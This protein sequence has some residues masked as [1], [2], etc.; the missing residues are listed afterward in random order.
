[1]LSPDDWCALHQLYAQAAAAMDYGNAADY[2]ALYTEDGAFS[3][4]AAGKE[5]FRHEGREALTTFA[6]GVIDRN[7]GLA[8]HWQCNIVLTPVEGGAR[9]T[10]HTMLVGTIRDNWTCNVL[11]IGQYDDRFV[12]TLE[13]W[14]ISRRIVRGPR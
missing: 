14:R 2:A 11:L 7:A 10:C 4:E 13:G 5:V 8:Q 12:R 3:R 6:Q 1:M 9:G